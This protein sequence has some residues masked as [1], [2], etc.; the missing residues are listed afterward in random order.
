VS[1]AASCA[2]P[3]PRL[4]QPSPRPRRRTSSCR[5]GT[6]SLDASCVMAASVSDRTLPHVPVHRDAGRVSS[7]TGYPWGLDPNGFHPVTG[8]VVL[9]SGNTNDQTFVELTG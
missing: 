8:E 2:T 3:K 9:L 6:T 4:I 7:G 1:G 5:A